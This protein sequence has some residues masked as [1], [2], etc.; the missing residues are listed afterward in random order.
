M[1]TESVFNEK[2]G[3]GSREAGN[4]GRLEV[5]CFYCNLYI[6]QLTY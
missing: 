6:I 5:I 4:G 3:L 1:G 2:W